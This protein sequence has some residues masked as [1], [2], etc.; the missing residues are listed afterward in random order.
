[1]FSLPFRFRRLCNKSKLKSIVVTR[2][3]INSQWCC[4]V[5]QYQLT[6]LLKRY[7]FF[8]VLFVEFFDLPLVQCLRQSASCVL[9]T[10]YMMVWLQFCEHYQVKDSSTVSPVYFPRTMLDLFHLSPVKN[11][12]QRRT[13][14]KNVKK[15][16]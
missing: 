4:L 11:H 10:L 6:K 8:F 1:M 2:F 14:T 5:K 12:F 9:L 16:N 3:K 15:N 7:Y 13:G